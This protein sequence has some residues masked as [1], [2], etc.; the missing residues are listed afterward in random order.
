MTKLPLENVLTLQEAKRLPKSTMVVA[1]PGTGMGE[2]ILQ[3][4]HC[5]GGGVNYNV[6]G[7]EGGH[8]NFAPSG[9]LEWEYL[10]Y[11]MEDQPEFIE[12]FGYL[13][14]EQAFCGPGIPNIYTFFC[15]KHS[16]NAE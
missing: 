12:K 16:V 14:T 9:P 7:T 10:K 8:K 5:K 13:S 4:C 1:G 3:P 6:F 15:K 2:C 11:V